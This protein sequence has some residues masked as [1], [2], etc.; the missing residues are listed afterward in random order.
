MDRKLYNIHLVK[1][2]VNVLRI[3][4]KRCRLSE[5]FSELMLFNLRRQDRFLHSDT[6]TDEV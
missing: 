5:V 4:H 3:K 2:F 6:H 1:L